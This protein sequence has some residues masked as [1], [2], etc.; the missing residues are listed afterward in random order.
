[1]NIREVL[2]KKLYPVGSTIK[3]PAP[4]SHDESPTEEIP[5]GEFHPLADELAA[6]EIVGPHYVAKRITLPPWL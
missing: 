5:V 4:Q 1:M 3:S 6:D 2:K